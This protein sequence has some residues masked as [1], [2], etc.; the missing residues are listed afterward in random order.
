ME[1]KMMRVLIIILTLTIMPFASA[2]STDM[3]KEYSSGETIIAEI[4]GNIL[5]PLSADNVKLKRINSEV[6]I[7]YDLKRIGERYYLWMIAP[8][9]PDN[10]TLIIKNIATTILG[11]AEKIDFTQNFTVLTNLSDYSIRPGFIFTQEDFSVKVQLNEDA[12]K[13]IS[14]DFPD[15][16]EVVLKPGENKIS[17]SIKD[18]GN[19]GFIKINIGKYVLPADIINKNKQVSIKR[20][21]AFSPEIVE[22]EMLLAE[23]EKISA[24]GLKSLEKNGTEIIRLKYDKDKFSLSPD[25]NIT[26]GPNETIYFNLTIKNFKTGE[27]YDEVYA[28]SSNFSALLVVKARIIE[29]RTLP[30]VVDNVENKTDVKKNYRCSEISNGRFCSSNELCSGQSLNALDGN[31]CV[32]VCAAKS[33]GGSSWIG[34]LIAAIVI[35]AVAIVYVKYKKTHAEKNPLQ[36]KLAESAKKAP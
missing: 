14:A 9:T 11:Q 33:S 34:Y 31:C 35:V 4:S 27:L 15:K 22:S 24:V 6:P 12:D 29:N 3:K 13:T 10:Y 1:K 2:I 18:F 32:G 17:F 5:E 28:I 25:S 20:G 30:V 21:F 26:I 36:K 19:V 8:S 7:E 23:N 16:R